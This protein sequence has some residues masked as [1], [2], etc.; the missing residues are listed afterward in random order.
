[1]ENDENKKEHILQQ[2]GVL[3][4]F[5]IVSSTTLEDFMEKYKEVAETSDNISDLSKVSK[6]LSR[7]TVEIRFHQTNTWIKTKVRS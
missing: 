7:D 6:L 4:E 5:D 2:M 1:M 3:I